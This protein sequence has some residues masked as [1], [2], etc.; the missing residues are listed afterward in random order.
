MY[1][2]VCIMHIWYIYVYNIFQ[3]ICRTSTELIDL[4][5]PSFRITMCEYVLKSFKP[6]EKYESRNSIIPTYWNIYNIYMYIYNVYPRQNF[7][8]INPTK[9]F[10][11]QCPATYLHI[12]LRYRI[13]KFSCNFSLLYSEASLILSGFISRIQSF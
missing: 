11:V 3:R 12:L 13:G 8:E 9:A 1:I 7:A 10:Q 6:F 4:F 2:R 5:R